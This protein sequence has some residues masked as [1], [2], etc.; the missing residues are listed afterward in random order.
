MI[1]AHGVER[2]E[3]TPLRRIQATEKQVDLIV[4]GAIRVRLCPHGTVR[5]RNGALMKDMANSFYC[6]PP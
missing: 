6:G 3:P 4:M 5:T 1:K 2:G